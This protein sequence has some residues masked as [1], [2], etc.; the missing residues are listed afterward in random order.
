MTDR[1]PLLS[2][3]V[4]CYNESEVLGALYKRLSESCRAATGWDYEIILVDDGSKDDTRAQIAAL[5]EADPHVVGVFLSRNH[6][7]QLALS[8]GLETARGER[9]FILDADLQDPPEC[10]HPMMKRMDAGAQVVYGQRLRRDG[11]TLFKKWTAKAFYRVLN[12]L[13][14]VPIPVD[15]GD[16]RLMSRKALD[17]LA[18]MPERHRF[19]RG[20]VSW[21]G[22]EQEAYLYQ[23][24]ARFAGDTKYPLKKMI[25]F[26]AD[27]ITSFSIRPL[28]IASVAGVSCAAMSGV[29]LA[30]VL[31]GHF[32]GRTA[33]GWASIVTVMLICSSLQLLVMGLMGEYLGRLYMEAKG[34]PLYLIDRIVGREVRAE[35]SKNRVHEQIRTLEVKLD[36][37]R[38]AG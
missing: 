18:S 5:A 7:H 9:V 8:A 30:Y 3:V 22:L 12:G 33:P 2:A 14:D 34:R 35:L 6:G 15:T 10:L 26:A 20:M 28:K 38:K 37:L 13:S 36:Q 32:T 4:P 21:I 11:E 1:L 16:F 31:W 23:R 29:V 19:I 27:A 17:M 25:A 24:D